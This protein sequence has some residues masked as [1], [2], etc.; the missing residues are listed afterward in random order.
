M[1]DVG[2]VVAQ[3]AEYDMPQLPPNHP[4]LDGKYKRFGPKKKAWY[5]LRKMTL[6]TGREVIT[7]AFGFF[8]GENRNT[9]PVKVDAESM[10]DA[11]RAEM[12]MKQ[13][14]HEAKEAE[15][16]KREIQLAANRAR[17]QWRQAVD[18]VVEHDYLVR[19]QI[20]PEGVRVGDKGELLIPMMRAGQMVGLQKIDAAGEKRYSTGMDKIGAAF[21]LGQLDGAAVIAVG[22]GYATCRTA[23]MGFAIHGLD[24]PAVGAFDAG[25]LQH[26]AKIL[27]QLYPAAVLIFLVDD[28]YLQEQRFIERLA[29]DFD[30]HASV[31]VDGA[32]HLVLADDGD[33]V[34]VTAGWR[35]DAHGISFIEADVRKGRRFQILK[36]E[37]AG[38]AKS[39]AAAALVGNSILAIPRFADRAGRKW[40][41]WNDLHVE[42]SLEIAAA[43]LFSFHP[44][45]KQ[46]IHTLSEPAPLDAAGLMAGLVAK[47]EATGHVFSV[48]LAAQAAH[49]IPAQA[50]A[51]DAPPHPLIAT[52][53]ADVYVPSFAAQ[54]AHNMPP[55]GG[56]PDTAASPAPSPADC[57]AESGMPVDALPPPPLDAT[58]APGEEVAPASGLVSL[59]WALSHCALIQGTTDVWDSVNQ[60]RMKSKAFTMMVGKDAAKAWESSE[61][62]RA[63]SP[64]ALP[65]LVRGIA[66]VEGGKGSDVLF[67]LLERYTLLYP[68]KTLWDHDKRMVVSYDAMSLSRGQFNAERWLEHPM[69]R[70]IDLENLVF[71]PTQQVDLSTH[72]NMFE[73]FPLKPKANDE[74]ASLAVELLMSLLSTEE[75]MQA[76]LLH[77]VLCWLAYPLQHPGA[78]MQTAMLFFGRKQGTGKSL[79]FEGIVKPI[80]G[81]YGA[82]GGQNQLDASYT[83]WRSQKL[84]VLF[85][86]ILSR[87][88]KY[89]GIGLI[90]HMITG[91]DQAISQKFK[92]DRT[93]ANHLNTVMLSNEFQAVPLEPDDRRFLVVDVRNDLAP[94]LLARI[95]A[96]LERG[97]IEAFYAFLL[98]YP[99]GDFNPH[100]KPLMTDA[101]QRVI[102]FGLPDWEAFY[103]AWSSGELEAPFCSC[104]STDLF[105]VYDRYCS[106]YKLRGQSLTKFAELMGSILKKDRQWVGPGLK[107]K[108]L[109]TII[110]VPP[111]EDDDPN[112]SLEKRIER[113]REL[114]DIKAVI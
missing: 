47:L 18:C 21:A 88:D 27:R 15:D 57:G 87:Q 112:E 33:E 90:K 14:A 75:D 41:D 35:N 83:M 46:P 22:E 51:D 36:Y 64:R 61:K 40:T 79:F 45:A 10:T 38:L 70:E 62:R 76:A 31:P 100:T 67:S 43:Q 37:N 110:H 9:V 56:G 102:N 89:A 97:L 93:E 98:E 60:V 74:L 17:D 95:S 4:I 53:G 107:K 7:G 104:L 72:I 84:F 34:R 80:Y 86:E 32:E 101:K 103:R 114:A 6:K 77:W 52:A 5:I 23:R 78:K 25:N 44:A 55:L 12:Q 105:A 108:K 82:T 48:P 28:D 65:E 85:E 39:T 29:S 30:V 54:A 92:D 63:I 13:R 11:E 24:V 1:S 50:G 91:R 8:Q 113:F 69:R 111:Q 49:N 26:V 94:D 73:G 109:L 20:T 99:L 19:K 96:V 66:A 3:M 106:K 42:E 59:E 81:S 68:T 16:R 58:A 2:Q 71:D